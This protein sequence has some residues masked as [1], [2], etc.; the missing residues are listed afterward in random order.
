[1]ERRYI[2]CDAEKCTGC[3]IC[4]FACSSGRE[5]SFALELSRIRVVQSSPADTRSMACRFCRNAPCVSVCPRG[6]LSM[7][8]ENSII[9][10]DK[11]R[12][13]GCGWCI[14]SCPFGAIVLDW[15][16]K[17]VV[18]CDLC[19]GLSQ[20]RCIQF[21]PKNALSIHG[22]DGDQAVSR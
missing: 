19:L 22:L 16:T 1:M 17:T 9:K 5:G 3:R 10:L 21:C 12:C 18:M 11:G 15:G 20:P 6:A 4:E 2:L 14:E 13:A 7:D 8:E